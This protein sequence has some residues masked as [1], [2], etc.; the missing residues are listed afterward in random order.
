MIFSTYDLE[1]NIIIFMNQIY[2]NAVFDSRKYKTEQIQ[3]LLAEFCEQIADIVN[4]CIHK[5]TIA[6]TPSDFEAL[7]ITQEELDSLFDE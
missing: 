7:D 5:N 6:F 3:Q 4:Y 1:V 2:V